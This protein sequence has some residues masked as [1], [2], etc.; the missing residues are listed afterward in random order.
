MRLSLIG[1]HIVNKKIFTV[2]IHRFFFQENESE[3]G[4]NF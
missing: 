4:R 2:I 1:V 3:G